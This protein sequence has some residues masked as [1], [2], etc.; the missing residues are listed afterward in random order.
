MSFINPFLLWALPLISVP[1]I[2]HLLRK[3]K[4]I[5]IEWAAMDFLMDAVQE[6]KKRFKM[7]DLLLLIL[8]TLLI[9]FLILAL[10]RPVTNLVSGSSS[11]PKLIS[12]DDSFSMASKIGSQSRFDRA[13]ETAN[14]IN[15]SDDGPKALVINSSSPR[16][17][18]ANFSEDRSLFT[19]TLKQIKVGDF[20]GDALTS[21]R[22]CLDFLKDQSSI[23]PSIYFLSDFQESQWAQPEALLSQSIK[24]LQEKSN[25]V[26]VHMGDE[27][28][29]NLSIANFRALQDAAKLNED[30]WFTVDLINHGTE[31]ASDLEVRFSLNGELYESVSTN[32][33]S[34]QQVT[35]NFKCRVQESGFHK[36]SAE[37]GAD[38]NLQDNTC[39]SHF[40]A[41]DKLKVLVVQNF[42][43]E[44]VYEKKSL[45]FDFALNPFP[46]ASSSEKALYEFNWQDAQV[47]ET[48]DLNNYAFI[49]LDDLQAMTASEFDSVQQYIAQGG[50][51][52][53]NLGASTDPENFNQNFVEGGVVSWPLYE[54][55]FAMKK[56]GDFLPTQITNEDSQLWSFADSA[57]SLGS[58]KIKQTFGLSKVDGTGQSYME[59]KREEEQNLSLI[60]SFEYGKG[61]VMVFTSGMDLEWNNFATRPYFLPL[62]RQLSSQLIKDEHRIIERSVG[63][64]L[65]KELSDDKSRSTFDLSTPDQLKETYNVQ[66]KDQKS[67]LN[68]E[69][70]KLAGTYKLKESGSIQ[71]E[72]I[73]VNLDS[74]ESTVASMS[75][76]QLKN[77]YPEV[78]VMSSSDQLSTASSSHGTGLSKFFLILAILCWLGENILGLIISRR[79]AS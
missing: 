48:E 46:G 10:A 40:Y 51:V 57:D 56:G 24:E 14:Q 58:F 2:I 11:E 30:A 8:R 15:T 3:N 12:L 68:I 47:L 32:I 78:T 31:D 52:L 7:E 18:I 71:E 34:G 61:K 72:L 25:L 73:S 36:I 64:S 49:I 75:L 76:E 60:S 16:K 79:A 38:I 37:I 5:E 9:L 41:T 77:T 53:V 4:V 45:F 44:S 17:L 21:V 55:K 62:C 39:Y 63:E 22:A 35:V 29:E 33:P 28:K 27:A 50:G 69:E 70:F 20:G 67:F 54:E 43:P 66:I 1:V 23:P 42:I 19:E 6:Q 74:K 26:F 65:Y 13:V 59:L